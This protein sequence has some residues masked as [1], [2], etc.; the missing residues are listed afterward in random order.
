MRT[1]NVIGLALLAS[2]VAACGGTSGAFE[3]P[4]GSGPAPDATVTAPGEEEPDAGR[5]VCRPP[6]TGDDPNPLTEASGQ[7]ERFAGEDWVEPVMQAAMRDHADEYAGLW[8][9]Q[10]AGEL[11]VMLAADDPVAVLE[12]LRTHTEHPDAL[13][14]MRATYTE[15]EL[16]SLLDEAY[17][18]LQAEGS[19]V[20]GHVDTL[21]NRVE[22]QYEGDLTAVD[23][24]LGDLAD[25]PALR[26]VRPECAETVKL[27]DG[28]TALP[29]GGSTCSMMQA[30]LSGTL[31]GDPA[32]GCLWIEAAD[33]ARFDVLWPRGWYV[34]ADGVVHDHH[35]EPRAVV[36]DD[37]E[38]GGGHSPTAAEA[39]P[40][41]CLAGSQDAF[42]L[43]SLE[44]A[45]RG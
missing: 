35:G 13:V 19:P 1:G 15:A 10:A 20:S 21:R 5:D 44:S 23:D 6:L 17:R 33:G 22:L 45:G 42:V 38:A 24:V 14:C 2:L 29:G 12:D 3:P 18:A 36:G 16:A 43:G 32:T 4:I 25:H 28:A 39:L 30:L 41:T 11:V 8:L 27:P 7:H 9:D 26:V 40:E 37:V 34:T 31:A